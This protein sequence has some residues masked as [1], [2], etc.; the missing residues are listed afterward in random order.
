MG[1]PLRVIHVHLRGV[2]PVVG[3]TVKELDLLESL[4]YK[5]VYCPDGVQSAP[6]SAA[7][8]LIDTRARLPPQGARPSHARCSVVILAVFVKTPASLV[9]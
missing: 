4:I 3:G 5:R 7:A 9:T 1:L 6:L 8:I 2:I